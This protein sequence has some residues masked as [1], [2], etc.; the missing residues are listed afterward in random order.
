MTHY[1]DRAQQLLEQHGEAAIMA[2]ILT[3]RGAAAERLHDYFGGDESKRTCQA[4]AHLIPKL[5]TGTSPKRRSAGPDIETPHVPDREA[6]RPDLPEFDR[7]DQAPTADD[8]DIARLD[9][10]EPGE[11]ETPIDDLI[12]DRRA[13]YLRTREA[14]AARQQYQ[15]A[16]HV[17][18]P[19]A[20]AHVGDPHLD[21]DGCDWPELLRV[22]RVVA[23]T[24][25]MYGGSIG[26]VSNN[27]PLVG[28]LARLW[29]E[30]SSTIPDS[31]RLTRWYY[32]SIPWLY[33]VLGNHDRWN[34][35]SQVVRY[36]TH[37]A[38][39]RVLARHFARLEL[40]F[41]RGEPIRVE[42]RHDFAGRSIWNR[43]HGPM[44]ASKLDPWAH[45]YVGGHRH[46]WTSHDEEG[47]DGVRRVALLVR[48][49]KSCDDYAEEHQWQEHRYG[50][51]GVTVL[52]P[53]ASPTERIRVIWD[54]EHAADYLAWLRQRAGITVRMG[55]DMLGGST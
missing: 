20:I 36:I 13:V 33:A 29:G 24:P 5:K 51:C 35:G 17:P 7:W 11:G 49:F 31:L 6:T 9:A 39:I 27:W 19:I 40:L 45:L 30:Q 52:D 46:V 21:D 4:L 3:R 14:W 18:G 42:A 15:V 10:D 26:D 34:G 43:A 28:R 25:G 1:D 23:S 50:H 37:G 16:V 38:Q 44:R 55:A 32:R 2:G 8:I 54:V 41:P 53:L 22:L 47:A 12:A 48:G